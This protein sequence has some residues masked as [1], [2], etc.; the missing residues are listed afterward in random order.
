MMLRGHGLQFP[1]GMDRW[2]EHPTQDIASVER[3]L[4]ADSG[5]IERGFDADDGGPKPGG[6]A[7]VFGGLFDDLHK[8][9][10]YSHG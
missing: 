9:G 5:R 2:A 4:V 8:S 10:T 7:S 1:A 3:R 6:E